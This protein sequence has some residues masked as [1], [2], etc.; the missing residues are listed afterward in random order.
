MILVEVD[1]ARG[2]GGVWPLGV[3]SHCVIY[4]IMET[5]MGSIIDVKTGVGWAET[6]CPAEMMEP[7]GYLPYSPTRHHQD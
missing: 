6:W 4:F 5:L 2:I 1:G 3:G 7:D